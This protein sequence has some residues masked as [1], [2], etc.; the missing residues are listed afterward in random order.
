VGSV[1]L[2]FA[3]QLAVIYW[4]PLQSVFKTVA[5][6]PVDLLATLALSSIVFWVAEAQKL[7]A[8]GGRP[9]PAR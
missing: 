8:G 1:A 4:A 5:L 7:I 6:E 2:T 3:L 9:R